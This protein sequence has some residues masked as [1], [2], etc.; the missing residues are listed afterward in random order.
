MLDARSL[1]YP[2]GRTW[3]NSPQPWQNFVCSLPTYTMVTGK[4]STTDL[5]RLHMRC[6][7]DTLKLFGGK[8]QPNSRRRSARIVFAT[9]EDKCAWEITYA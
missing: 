6:I 7:R 1:T 9:A 3:V 2:L 5:N 4:I 8:Y